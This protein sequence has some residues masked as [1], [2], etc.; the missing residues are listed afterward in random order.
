MQLLASLQLDP[1]I[2]FL[3]LREE[4]LRRLREMLTKFIFWE[5]Q[6][7][8][9]KNVVESHGSTDGSRPFTQALTTMGSRNWHDVSWDSSRVDLV[10]MVW[11]TCKSSDGILDA[12]VGYISCCNKACYVLGVNSYSGVLHLALLLHFSSCMSYQSLTDFC[13]PRWC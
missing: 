1:S 5:L 7:I 8:A 2:T 11:F 13:S 6:F 3:C 4:G 10:I 12:P 9:K